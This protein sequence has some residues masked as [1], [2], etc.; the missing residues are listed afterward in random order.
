MFSLQHKQLIY[1][2]LTNFSFVFYKKPHLLTF[3]EANQKIIQKNRNQVGEASFQRTR[4]LCCMYQEHPEDILP[5]NRYTNYCCTSLTSVSVRNVIYRTVLTPLRYCRLNFTEIHCSTSTMY[6]YKALP[7]QAYQEM[8]TRNKINA[9]QQG[10]IWI[11][12]ARHRIFVA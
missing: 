9:D 6:I 8:P 1:G 2:M 12:F 5:L 7:E 11:C 4:T 10:F 3:L